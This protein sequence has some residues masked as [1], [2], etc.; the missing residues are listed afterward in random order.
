MTNKI[1]T[2]F[3][4][5]TDENIDTLMVLTKTIATEKFSKLLE[6][7][8][9][10]NYIAENFNKDT[11]ITEVNTMSNQW[12]IVYADDEPVGYARITSKGNRHEMLNRKR[13]IRIADFG[14][15]E[16]FSDPAIIIPLFQKC[17]SVCK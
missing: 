2:K 8:V 4:V 6:G 3:T 11:L 15:L 1:T 5:G 14:I 10:E 7:S 13:S 16:N 17:L 12:L 9:L